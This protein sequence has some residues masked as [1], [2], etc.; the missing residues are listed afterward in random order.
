VLT[1]T[2]PDM[3]LNRA[4]AAEAASAEFGAEVSVERIR[5]WE[6]RGHLEREGLN[7]DGQPV[8]KAVEVAK[9]AHKLRG[10]TR[11]SAA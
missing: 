8:Y 9:A 5:T 3:L 7:E 10:F 4:E 6:R 11:V 1:I 2:G